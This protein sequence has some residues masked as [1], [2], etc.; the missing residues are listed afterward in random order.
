MQDQS[1]SV[2]EL[3]AAVARFVAEREWH[4]YHDPK[5]LAMSIAI[6]AAELMEHVQWVRTEELPALLREPGRLEQIGEE[7]ADITC[8]VLSLAH[9]LKLDLSAT[10]EQKLAKNAVKYPVAQFRGR[11][12]KPGGG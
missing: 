10:V 2:A 8:Y 4:S 3:G 5:N 6:E 11:Y 12:Y 9:V 7:L 1:T